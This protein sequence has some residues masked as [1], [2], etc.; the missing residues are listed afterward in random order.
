MDVPPWE[1]MSTNV[2]TSKIWDEPNYRD[3]YL[4]RLVEIAD[5]VSNGWFEQTAAREYEQIRAAV[6]E[7]PLTR[8]HAR[9]SMLRT[10]SCSSS[11]GSGVMSCVSMW[12]VLR[13]KWSARD[14][15]Q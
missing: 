7:D 12:G 4:S 8:T 5:L 13:R 11:R 10:S 14:V 6:Y 2:L 1:N 15:C 9:S 3:A